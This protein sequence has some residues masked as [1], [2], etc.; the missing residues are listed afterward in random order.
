[1][2]EP[3]RKFLPLSKIKAN[4]QNPRIISESKLKKLINSL[5]VFPKMMSLRPITIDEN[6]FVL[7]GNMRQTALNR[8]A[9]WTLDELQ[10]YMEATPEFNELP[11][12]G[13]E[14]LEFWEKFL[15]KPQV[16]VQ[17]ATN[18]TDEERK[19]F[20][21]KDNV[22]FG[23]WDYDE[24]ESWDQEKLESWGVDAQ[25]PDFGGG[26]TFSNIGETDG[27]KEVKETEKLSEVKFY[28]VYNTPKNT[29]DINLRES[30]NLD[31][32]EKKLDVI[33]QSSLTD[34]QKE[35]MKLLAYRFIKI[36]FESVANY[37]AFNAS[38]EEKRVIERLR[39]VLVDGAI[40]G[41]IEDNMLSVVEHFEY[42]NIVEEQEET[43]ND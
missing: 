42:N 17:Y 14:A 41:F 13:Y 16:E 43:E 40:D 36:D 18:L 19:Q 33:N 21:I 24:L 4:Q 27:K 23:D 15:E 30:I 35:V 26:D 29:P 20:I 31:Q 5:L 7:G 22:S 2:A 9:Q 37:Y 39:C 12:G 11:D 34:E 10:Q 28:D 8:I 38:D 32:F 1:M 3:K 25:L 6:N